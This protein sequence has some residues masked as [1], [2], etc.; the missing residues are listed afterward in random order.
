MQNHIMCKVTSGP[1]N[2]NS[3]VY[4]SQF[5]SISRV[6]GVQLVVY[7]TIIKPALILSSLCRT[8]S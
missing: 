2:I 1:N 7:S 8:A 3:F 6:Q 4:N 5:C